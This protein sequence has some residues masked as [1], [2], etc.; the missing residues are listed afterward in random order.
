MNWKVCF[1]HESI[2]FAVK[3]D[4]PL[5]EGMELKSGKIEATPC[6]CSTDRIFVYDCTYFANSDKAREI[7]RGINKIEKFVNEFKNKGFDVVYT[8][9]YHL[10]RKMKPPKDNDGRGF[11]ITF[12][13]DDPRNTLCLSNFGILPKTDWKIKPDWIE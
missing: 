11:T 9:K 5:F 2:E 3:S 8:L 10:E 4:K 13:M 1:G 7:K 12:S 6:D